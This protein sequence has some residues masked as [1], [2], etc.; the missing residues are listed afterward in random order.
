MSPVSALSFPSPPPPPSFPS[1]ST[2]PPGPQVSTLFIKLPTLGQASY[3]LA[4]A[5][6]LRV[7]EAALKWHG[8][9][10]QLLTARSIDACRGKGLGSYFDRGHRC[11]PARGRVD[12]LTIHAAL[13]PLPL[14]CRTTRAPS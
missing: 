10:R 13:R 1:P 14:A 3:F 9:L 7:Q 8:T 12:R 2:R 5:I 6:V 11:G 4:Q